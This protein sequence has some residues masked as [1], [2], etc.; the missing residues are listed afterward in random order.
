MWTGWAPRRNEGI[1]R[2]LVLSGTQGCAGKNCKF[3]HVDPARPSRP[4]RP[5]A[6]T[7]AE[8]PR[9]VEKK[10]TKAETIAALKEKLARMKGPPK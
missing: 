1:L 7:A 5:A 2:G 9:V 8:L 6:L 4:D 10:L 3:Q